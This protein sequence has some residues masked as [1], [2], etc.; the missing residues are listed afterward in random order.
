MSVDMSQLSSIVA[1]LESVADRLEKGSPVG[2]SGGTAEPSTGSDDPPIVL[3]FDEFLKAKA[4]PVEAAASS[5]GNADVS[6]ST[7]FFMDLLRMVRSILVATGRCRKPKDEEWGKIF[8][9]AQEIMQKANKACDNRSEWFQNRKAAAEA[10]S[11]FMMVTMPNPGAGVQ[12]ALEAMDFHAV[13]VMQKKD[14]P[15]TAWINAMKTCLKDLVEWCKDN[16]KMGLDWKVGGEDPVP[17]FE[18]CPVG[19]QAA[20]AAPKAA[21]KGKGKGG[22]PPPVPKGGFK[23]PPPT[24][25]RFGAPSAKPAPSGGGMSEIF[26]AIASKGTSGLK[27]VTDDMK[28]KNL[29]DV[30]AKEAKAKAPAAPKAAAG[31]FAKGPKGPPRKELEKDINWIIEN[32]DGETL[33]LDEVDMKQSVCL[34]NCRNTTVKL[35]AK[36][37]SISVDG[38]ERSSVVTKDVLSVVELVNSDR[39]Q[40]QIQGKVMMVSVDKCN[41]FG[42]WLNK[43]SLECEIVSSKSSE[44][45]VTIPDPEGDELDTIELPIPEQF[46]TKVVGKKCKT[47]VSSLYS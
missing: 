13:K 10:L 11:L 26:E 46:V 27:K 14:P 43:E 8:P 5:L 19:S 7:T 30:P 44:M 40:I 3:S 15:Q 45:N 32:Y 23:A 22:G 35:G 9:P 18:A 24:E 2:A 17:Y 12:N 47:E 37:K 41:G 1:R 38:C 42:L 39:C 29:K 28:C 20:A 33:S 31:R 6:E 21:G 36:V 16:C 34:I 25:E 4:E